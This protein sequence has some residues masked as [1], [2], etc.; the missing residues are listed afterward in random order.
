MHSAETIPRS[1]QSNTTVSLSEFSDVVS[2]SK[3]PSHFPANNAHQTQLSS[4]NS[5]TAI[6]NTSTKN[7]IRQPSLVG[8][9]LTN[10]IRVE[11][12]AGRSISCIHRINNEPKGKFCLVEVICRLYFNGCSVNEFLFTL[13]NVF[14][15]T[16]YSC[17]DQEEKA[18]I[19]YYS[20][21]VTALKCN[22]LMNADDLDKFYPQLSYVFK[23]TSDPNQQNVPKM[24]KNPNRDSNHKRKAESPPA[25]P[26]SKR[27][28]EIN[29]AKD[30]QDTNGDKPVI[31]SEEDNF[32]II[33]LDD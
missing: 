29:Q 7:N 18:F 2:Q 8:N 33:I 5:Q 26:P 19:Q 6:Q 22:K 21:Q 15:V 20:L 11:T 17:T 3:V 4:V 23:C 13:K 30:N 1:S 16:V 31:V 14:R 28:G 9:S 27:S 32:S 12:V 10:S 24:S 25:L